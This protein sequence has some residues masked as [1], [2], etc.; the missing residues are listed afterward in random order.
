MQCFEY[1]GFSKVM[2][3]KDY[4][5]VLPMQGTETGTSFLHFSCF[6]V[7]LVHSLVG[8]GMGVICKPIRC[9][10]PRCCPTESQFHVFSPT[11]IQ[12]NV[13]FAV[14]WAESHRVEVITTLF[15][16]TMAISMLLC[17]TMFSC[18]EQVLFL[19]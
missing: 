4:G 14:L 18:I 16:S 8:G 3:T 2:F 5:N 10:S 17:L 19:Y 9:G 7:P 15:C 11:V 6:S 13:V 12:K 1:I